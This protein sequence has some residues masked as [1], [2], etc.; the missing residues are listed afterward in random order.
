MNEQPIRA[1]RRTP[2]S[3]L[4]ALGTGAS[5]FLAFVAYGLLAPA[6]FRATA[7]I[8]LRPVGDKPLTLPTSPPASERLRQAALSQESLDRV[9]KQLDLRG[10]TDSHGSAR[11]A[12]EQQL[13]VVST[14][15]ST[16]D[17]SFKSGD[18]SDAQLK[19]TVLAK[20]AAS[21]ALVALAPQAVD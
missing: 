18:P 10:G 13:E 7:Q 5:V 20:Q 17:V 9:A 6:T 8:V 14:S 3:S 12:L 21:Q 4:L 19:A 2:W 11:R 16:F 15:A 1:P